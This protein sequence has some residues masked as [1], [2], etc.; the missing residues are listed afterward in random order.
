MGM[1]SLDVV[2]VCV[3][4]NDF[5]LG[6]SSS[7]KRSTLSWRCVASRHT[8]LCGPSA[9]Y[10]LPLIKF[11]LYITLSWVPCLVIFMHHVLVRISYLYV[12]LIT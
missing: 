6:C 4:G 9:S 11:K 5:V 3:Q 10:A 8:G 1:M 12:L 2:V 7:T